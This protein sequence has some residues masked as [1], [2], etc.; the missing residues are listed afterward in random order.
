MNNKFSLMRNGYD[1]Y[2]VDDKIN[3]LLVEI[4]ALKKNNEVLEIK[5]R[6]INNNFSTLQQRYQLLLSEISFREKTADD[7]SR[8]ALKEA[9]HIIG[10]A[11]GNADT[12]VSEALLT[13]KNVL[14]EVN[15]IAHDGKIL[16]EDMQNRLIELSTALDRFDIPQIPLTDISG[17]RITNK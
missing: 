4:M 10:N 5:N 12:I 8:L 11:Q 17:K 13:A 16:K 9:N 15:R 1:R 7:I 2:E 14:D 3:S 6:E